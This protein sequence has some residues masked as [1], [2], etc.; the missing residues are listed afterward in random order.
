MTVSEYARNAAGELELKPAELASA[1][2]EFSRSM[3]EGLSGRPSC[4]KM[5]P[6]FISGPTG[7]ERGEVMA[8]DFGG[9]NVRILRAS[10]DGSGGIAV[11]GRERF[12]LR[13]PDRGVDY[14]SASTSAAELFGY[15]ARKA[16]ELAP[17]GRDYPLGHTFSFPC[18]QDGINSARL[19]HWTKEIKTSGVLDRDVNAL[20]AE[21]LSA[22]NAT[23]VRPVA[24]I[25]DT[26]GTL[27]AAAY[28]RRGVDIASICG[29]G[30]NSCYIEPAHPL[31]G[32]AMIV[33]M[34]SGN[35]DGL[36]RTEWDI[37]LDESSDRPGAQRTEKMASG[38]YLGEVVLQVLSSMAGAGFIPASEA[39]GRRGALG[40]AD[41]DAVIADG[42]ELA[43]T[44]RVARSSLGLDGLDRESLA[45]I[46]DIARA[47]GRRSARAVAATF[48]GAL[49]RI[50]PKIAREHVIAIDGSLYER[51]PGY[52]AGI[53]EALHDILG[54]GSLRV[55]TVLA[56]DGSGIGA[57]IA[58]AIAAKERA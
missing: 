11:L 37:R 36:R 50:D 28:E 1:A 35:F 6:S 44:A 9:T 48:S 25:N 14:T 19:I 13:D 27:L 4:L 8:V 21:A 51:M 43:E 24:V 46:R 38:H 56:K 23:R 22:R 12:P 7:E 2:K 39:L 16:A 26:V 10:L 42:E 45:A 52:D 5:L 54:Q 49:L 20:L 41:L 47:V 18:A 33:N 30:H 32:R 57:A 58:A 15:I 40:G 29:T 34:E 31:T 53:K 55:S 3:E 17:E